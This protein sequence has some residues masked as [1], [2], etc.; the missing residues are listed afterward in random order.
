M[1]TTPFPTTLITPLI[2]L[3][4]NL[5]CSILSIQV[6]SLSLLCV[7]AYLLSVYLAPASDD[8]GDA[9]FLEPSTSKLK[10]KPV[11]GVAKPNVATSK[12]PVT[13]VLP[14]RASARGLVATKIRPTAASTSRATATS[15]TRP[16][17]PAATIR[18]ATTTTRPATTSRPTTVTKPAVAARPVRSSATVKAISPR[19]QVGSRGAKSQVKPMKPLVPVQKPNTATGSSSTTRSGVV[20]RPLSSAATRKVGTTA[21]G[22]TGKKPVI[23]TLKEKEDDLILKFDVQ[24]EIEEFQFDV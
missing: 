1:R 15:A 7:Y 20:S 17:R 12:I 10:Q 5:N 4:P 2:S 23:P 16:T 9:L 22:L 8:D 6:C 14:T 11:S 18:T 13:K 24:G 21:G 19:K 3:R